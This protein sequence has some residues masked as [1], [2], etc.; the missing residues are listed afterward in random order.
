RARSAAAAAAEYLARQARADPSGRPGRY[1][2]GAE[3]GQPRGDLRDDRHGGGGGSAVGDRS[4][5][6]GEHSGVA[7]NGE[8]GRYRRGDVAGRSGR[9]A[10]RTRRGDERGDPGGDGER[11]EIGGPGAARVAGG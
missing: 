6:A 3:P 11:A 8:G 4:A 1:R 2:R 10:S 7:R 9:R 5:D